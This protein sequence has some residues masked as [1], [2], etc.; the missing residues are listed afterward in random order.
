MNVWYRSP[1][2]APLI[3]ALFAYP[4]VAGSTVE[5]PTKTEFERQ[6][7]PHRAV[8][9]MQLNS[10]DDTGPLEGARGAMTYSFQDRCEGW[11]VETKVF[12]VL[13]YSGR[14]DVESTRTFRTWE[15][16]D[17]LDFRFNVVEAQ[18]GQPEP[19]IKGVAVLDGKN[20]GG[21]AEY[22]K[23]RALKVQLP[24]GTVFPTEHI[25][26]LVDQAAAGAYHFGKT[27]FDGSA[28]KNPYEI[29]AII[30]KPRPEATAMARLKL[31]DARQWRAR[32]AY[33][34]VRDKTQ[35][36]EFELTVQ[37]REDG[38]VSQLIQDFG[39][40]TIEA[41]LDQIE[42]LPLAPDC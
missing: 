24:K 40:Y 27:V 34:P 26:L 29:S 8:Y 15:T 39:D 3:L 16:K 25:G 36:P 19:E 33:F 23:P 30:G 7:I 37:F 41:N 2:V 13:S 6:L 17:G 9:S 22:T 11:E 20:Q 38:I 35:T 42:I 1:I 12:L 28:L 14:P 10:E 32:M 18:N 31:P 5:N 4:S 21:V